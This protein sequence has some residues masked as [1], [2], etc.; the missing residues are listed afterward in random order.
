MK[1]FTQKNS[2]KPRENLIIFFSGFASLPSHFDFL[3]EAQDFASKNPSKN[4]H[5]FGTDFSVDFGVDFASDFGWDFD[6]L[7]CYDYSDFSECEAQIQ[8]LLKE[9]QTYKKIYLIAWSMGV[10]VASM[11]LSDFAKKHNADFGYD[12]DKNFAQKIAINGTN[13]G[14][15]NTYGIPHKIFAYTAKNIK[16]NAFK[17]ALFASRDFDILHLKKDF[18]L[19]D[20]THNFC[21]PHNLENE[22]ESLLD[23]Y[24]FYLQDFAQDFGQKSLQ[25]FDLNLTQNFAQKFAQNFLWDKAIISR[26][27]KVFPTN[28][29]EKF[30]AQNPHKIHTKII[31]TN[32]PHFAFLGF[33]NWAKILQA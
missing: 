18:D 7:M 24:H 13:I 15:D 1:I 23:F 19:A 30:Y 29:C 31:Y 27:D 21:L 5:D 4:T 2:L 12:L 17:K 22:L 20:F 9:S 3:F 32:A 11:L 28:A 8:G 14:I 6:F 16:S 33:K 26:D 10:F 25:D